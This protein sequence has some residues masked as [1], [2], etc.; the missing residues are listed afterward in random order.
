MRRKSASYISVEDFIRSIIERITNQYDKGDSAIRLDLKTHVMNQA[1]ELG[2]ADEYDVLHAADALEKKIAARILHRV[3]KNILKEE[4][5]DD[6]SSAYRLADLFDCHICVNDVSQVYAKGI[7]PDSEDKLAARPIFG[8]SEKVTAWDA[9]EYIDRLFAKSKRLTPPAS[10]NIPFESVTLEEFM[11]DNE[12]YICVDIR[13][14]EEYM[15]KPV[16]AGSINIPFKKIYL[17]PHSV[18]ENKYI[19][20]YLYSDKEYERI[21]AADLLAKYGYTDVRVIKNEGT[22]V[23]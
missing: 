15:G 8:M 23:D 5:E 1:R 3:L 13:T 20:I 17:N 14:R 4:D 6:R 10:V 22:R 7:I 9:E 2:I 21:P 18:S 12:E 19:R 16:I 11:E